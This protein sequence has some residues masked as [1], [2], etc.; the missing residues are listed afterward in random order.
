MPFIDPDVTDTGMG[1][2]DQF[3]FHPPHPCPDL[4]LQ[5]VTVGDL[6]LFICHHQEDQEV[7]AI[8]LTAVDHDHHRPASALVQAQVIILVTAGVGVEVQG[9]TGV[10]V[11]ARVLYT[12]GEVHLGLKSRM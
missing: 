4:A 6:H 5:L 9:R 11:E 1:Q 10:G 3:P 2:V 7:E 12:D 8:L